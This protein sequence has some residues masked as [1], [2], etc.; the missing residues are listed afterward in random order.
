M[1]DPYSY[2]YYWTH[3]KTNTYSRR[4]RSLFNLYSFADHKTLKKEMVPPELVIENSD[5][6][7][8][9]KDT[10]ES[11]IYIESGSTTRT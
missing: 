3:A 11:L 1:G 5:F 6:E 2:D 8:F 10:I 9:L 4:R 7:Y